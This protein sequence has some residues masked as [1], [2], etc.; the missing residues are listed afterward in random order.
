MLSL[1]V[2]P[3]LIILSLAL[4]AMNKPALIRLAAMNQQNGTTLHYYVLGKFNIPL[5]DRVIA[6]TGLRGAPMLWAIMGGT[7]QWF[8]STP[9]SLP[10][11]APGNSVQFGKPGMINPSLL[12]GTQ[13]RTHTSLQNTSIYGGAPRVIIRVCSANCTWP[14]SPFCKPTAKVVNA[15]SFR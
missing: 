11:I 6:Y 9:L 13:L 1:L 5:I 2:S 4:T 7:I 12:F 14:R 15:E 3:I 8:G 10:L